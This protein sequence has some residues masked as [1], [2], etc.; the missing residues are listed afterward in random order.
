MGPLCTQTF[1]KIEVRDS[2]HQNQA[3][4]IVHVF[5]GERPSFDYCAMN[6]VP[7]QGRNVPV[8]PPPSDLHQP[9][10]PAL[11][12]A[13]RASQSI[14]LV[15]VALTGHMLDSG[16]CSPYSPRPLLVTHSPRPCPSNPQHGVALRSPS[17]QHQSTIW[18]PK[19]NCSFFFQS[20]FPT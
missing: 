15:S 16:P 3:M 17:T 5:S 6:N 1:R 13:P 8:P 9:L 19:T 7:A 18:S 4:R 20:N 2:M 14:R 10:S 12:A 11:S